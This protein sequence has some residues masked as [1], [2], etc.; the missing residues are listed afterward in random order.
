M[1]SRTMVYLE[2]EQVQAL[3]KRAKAEGISVAE[4][5]RRLVREHLT[6]PAGPKPV[7]K[8][9]YAALV[10]LGSSGRPGIGDA[11]DEHLARALDREHLR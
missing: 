8:E 9:A 1:T 7:P 6:E 10:G 3:K 4:L 11:H 5:M 2:P